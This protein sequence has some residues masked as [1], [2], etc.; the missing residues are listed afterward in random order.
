MTLF[1]PPAPP[2]QPDDTSALKT[3]ALMRE[4]PLTALRHRSYRMQMGRTNLM[5]LTI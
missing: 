3:L 4:C 2:R 5:H 1:H